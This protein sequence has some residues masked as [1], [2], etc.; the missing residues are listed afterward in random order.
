MTQLLVDNINGVFKYREKIFS[1]LVVAIFV[2]TA[3]YVYLLHSAITNVVAREELVKESRT[4]LTRVSELE[5]KYFLVKNTINAEL[6]HEKGFK[7]S[8][9]VSFISGQSLTAMANHNEL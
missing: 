8:D 7:D 9:T 3:S 5:A 6:A 4:I 1:F 2:M